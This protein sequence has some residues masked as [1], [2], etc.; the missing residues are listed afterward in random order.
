VRLGG[1]SAFYKGGADAVASIA[2]ATAAWKEQHKPLQH[3]A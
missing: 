1:H 2:G 3:N